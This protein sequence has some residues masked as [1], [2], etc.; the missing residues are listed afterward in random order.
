MTLTTSAGRPIEA[1]GRAVA[2]RA[3]LRLRDV[4]GI[5]RELI[6]L[7]ARHDKLIGDVETMK[8]LLDSLPAPVWARDADGRLIFVNCGL[9]PRGGSRRRRP[10]RWRASSNCSTAPRATS[11][12]QRARRRRDLSP[13]GCRRSSPASAASSTWSTRRAA[14][15]APAWRSTAPKPRPCAPSS[16]A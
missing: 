15:A 3:V 8:A 13:G 16:R 7:A 9:C 2:G 11:S 12:R 4:S 14:P 10:T 5:E 6:D 1:E